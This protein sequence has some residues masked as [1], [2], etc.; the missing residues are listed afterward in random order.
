MTL[1]TDRM[2]LTVPQEAALQ[3][4]FFNV[5]A[6]IARA[7]I[8]IYHG[9]ELSGVAGVDPDAA[10]RIYRAPEEVF[11]EDSL[12]SFAHL[13]ITDGHPPAGVTADNHQSTSIGTALDA[14]SR[15]ENFVAATLSIRDAAAIERLR[16][17]EIQ[18]IS[19]GYHADVTLAPGVTPGGEPYDGIQSHIRGN[20]IA[21]V[22]AARCGPECRIGAESGPLCACASCQSSREDHMSEPRKRLTDDGDPKIAETVA[23]L[24]KANAS[25][26]EALEA[27]QKTISR[28]TAELESKSGEVEAMSAAPTGD[29]DFETRVKARTDLLIQARSI[30]GDQ[31]FSARSDRDIR[32]AAIAHIYG[33]GFVDGASD[34]AL[35]GMFK[36]LMRDRAH[37]LDN[38]NGAVTPAHNNS[39]LMA[40]RAKRNARLQNAW[41]G[42][43]S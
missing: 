11:A 35:T 30:L 23:E 37:G 31:D 16:R 19:A 33:D 8:Q 26:S 2:A 5:R 32:R 21:L 15:E 28:L 18:Q 25:L 34:H 12:A 20:H 27:A 1:F 40:A 38:L 29:A 17:G 42:A 13:P 3:S 10:Y 7:G 9:S 22:D 43:R 39:S 41:K 14:V 36:V 6:R 4:G 24:K